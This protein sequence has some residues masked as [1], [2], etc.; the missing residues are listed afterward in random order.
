MIN[1]PASVLAL[2]ENNPVEDLMLAV[3][4]Q[5][6]PDIPVVSLFGQHDK[7]PYILVRR[8]GS[9]GGWD[10]DPRFTDYGRFSINT[11]TADP[12]GDE[13]SAL[14]SEAVRVVLRNAWLSHVSIPGI[15]SVTSIKMTHEPTRRT[16]W[17]TSTGP[18]QFAD[19][20]TGFW[21]YESIYELKVRRP[22]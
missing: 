8:I 21:R 10:G 18:V 19:L 1:L 11:L 4:R 15:G 6:L 14:L 22:N 12:D 20:P 2:V 17:A 13:K 5:A 3:L 16:D 9:L 7:P